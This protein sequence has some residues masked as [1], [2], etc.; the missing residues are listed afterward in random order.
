MPF[1]YRL[2]RCDFFLSMYIFV[3]TVLQVLF[4]M[5][6]FVSEFNTVHIIR[7]FCI[8]FALVANSVACG[9]YMSEHEIQADLAL[10][11]ELALSRVVSPREITRPNT[12]ITIV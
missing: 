11:L 5:D 2:P 9:R 12:I 8:F 3:W 6:L 10:D 4:F 7:L 1:G